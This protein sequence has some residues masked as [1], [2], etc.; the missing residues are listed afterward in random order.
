[1]PVL[2]YNCRNCGSALRFNAKTQD[3][4]CDYCGSIFNKSDLVEEE[5]EKAAGINGTAEG[6]AEDHHYPAQEELADQ[7]FNARVIGYSCPTCGAEI[8]TD[9][10]TA[11]TFCFY[12]HNPAILTHQLSGANRPSKVI[13]FSFPKKVV[14]DRFLEWCKKK[15]LLPDSFKSHHQLEML[16]GIYIPYWLFDCDVNGKL[17]AIATNVRSW[18]VGDIRYTETKTYDVYREM[19][20]LFKGIPAD[21][22]TKADDKLMETIEPFDFSGIKPFVLPYLSGFQAEKYDV[23]SSGVF[24]RVEKRIREYMNTL[25]KS[26]IKGYG[27]YSVK[28]WRI[29]FQDIKVEYALMPVWL[30]TYHYKGQSYFFAMNGQTGKVAGKLPLCR[31]KVL[32]YFL[33]ISAVL[34]VL[35]LLGGMIFL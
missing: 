1:M 3:W 26:T 2:S 5:T 10:T 23:D 8:I 27:H 22:S 11:A 19:R 18:Q 15:P 12:C 4:T 20:A 14:T 9:E 31:G 25:L 21:G 30:M 29:D 16:T 28:E 34:Y 6:R 35:M 32:K 24:P 33:G 13:P 7:E 17:S